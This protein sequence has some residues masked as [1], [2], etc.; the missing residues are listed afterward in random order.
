MQS[1]SEKHSKW[2]DPNEASVNHGF[3]LT[4]LDILS[5]ILIMGLITS[6]LVP[7]IL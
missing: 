1:N 5:S 6:L 3:H 7:L 2:V 4:A